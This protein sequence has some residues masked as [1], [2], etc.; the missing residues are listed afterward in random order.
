[1]PSSFIDRDKVVMKLIKERCKFADRQTDKDQ[2]NEFISRW[3][4]PKRP[5]KK[6][7]FE[8]SIYSLF[9]PRKKWCHL[10]KKRIKLDSI[11]R[12]ELKLKYTYLTSKKKNCTEN[13][14]LRL[15]EKADGIVKMA[16]NNKG[17]IKPP[18]VSVIE[19]KRKKKENYIV[20]RPV[21]SFELD[22]KIIFSLLNKY[23][24]EM[25][26]SYFKGCSYAFRM[27]QK[28]QYNLQHLNAI[29]AV[30]DYRLSHLNSTLYVAECDMQKF[31]DTINHNVIKTRFCLMLHRAI[32]D[33]AISTCEAKLVKRWFFIYIDCFN[34][35]DY[36]FVHNKK[37]TSHPF[38]HNI[39][40]RESYTCEIKWV[41]KGV[42]SYKYARK[43]KGYV[44]VPQGGALSG[45]IANIVMHYV[46]KKVLKSIAN[47]DVLYCRFC[48]DMILIG[49]NKEKVT[50]V[51][52]DYQKAIV[53]AKLIAHPNSE[54]KFKKMEE[55]WKGKT[56]T[57]YEW[58][59][60]G[61]NVFPWISFVGYDINWK[62][63]L[64]IRLSSF[65][66]QIAKQNMVANELLAPYKNGKK[67]RYCAASVKA[68]LISRLV[69][70]SVGRVNLW[71]YKDNINSHSWMSAFSILDKNPWSIKQLKELDKHRQV[72]I[73]R[74]KHDINNIDSTN[75]KND[76]HID[77]NRDL[78]TYTGCPFSY[79][80]QCFK[81]KNNIGVQ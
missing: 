77:S 6:S 49:E 18:H 45:L 41:D 47:N 31:Y 37:K 76:N 23:L 75:K 30:R 22:V 78:F 39:K 33:G 50:H 17:M 26:D 62:G 68:S 60:C 16:L 8:T 38:W 52:E 66:K 20:C 71:N 59:E 67:S 7:E 74:A 63:N 55:F 35:I 65:K 4:L 19:K 40:N 36:V 61:K 15:C 54:M 9:P 46:D 13:W 56:K 64:R 25:F 73:A 21:C 51:F 14:Y 80:G 44:G 1:M 57:P 48:D 27:P 53:S 69:G 34:F 28:G 29:K 3:D 24:T 81:Y 2:K 11:S 58:N 43:K 10:G 32:K 5:Q 72:V 42:L 12:N 70:M 79:Y